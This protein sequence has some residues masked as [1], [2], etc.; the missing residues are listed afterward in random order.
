VS[1]IVRN[2]GFT[3]KNWRRAAGADTQATATLITGGRTN[4]AFF[5]SNLFSIGAGPSENYRF[6]IRKQA[7]PLRGWR[8]RIAFNGEIYITR[9][10]APSW[11]NL[12]RFE[13]PLRHG[14]PF[15][16]FIYSVGQRLF[17]PLA[18][19]FRLRYGEKFREAHRFLRATRMGI[20]ATLYRACGK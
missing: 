1:G 5:Q 18:G 6:G 8:F 7:D 3:T 14:K 4:K 2:P 17:F 11:K 9:A 12:T 16:A 13:S 15:F 20:Q 10:A 19:M